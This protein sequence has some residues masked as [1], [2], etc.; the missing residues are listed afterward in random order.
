MDRATAAL[1]RTDASG[2]TLERTQAAEGGARGCGQLP[3][4]RAG[5][6][7]ARAKGQAGAA[8]THRNPLL[9]EEGST[10]AAATTHSPH[11]VN[12]CATVCSGALSALRHRSGMN[13][14]GDSGDKARDTDG[15][16]ARVR[17]ASSASLTPRRP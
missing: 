14:A 17:A 5:S 9:N 16:K 8:I 13:C 3:C 10:G 6:Q 2:R 12:E 4:A 7:T 15:S 11:A 1:P